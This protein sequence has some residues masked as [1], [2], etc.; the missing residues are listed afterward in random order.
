M[1]IDVHR[2]PRAR[3]DVRARA[4][5]W[6]EKDRCLVDKTHTHLTYDATERN[7]SLEHYNAQTQRP[8]AGACGVSQLHR[9][10]PP[11]VRSALAMLTTRQEARSSTSV[12][13]ASVT[14]R[15]TCFSS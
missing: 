14:S 7:V 8:E 12:D 11:T 4:R 15:L 6:V 3:R 13:I 2:G 1:R 9:P 10:H 5:R